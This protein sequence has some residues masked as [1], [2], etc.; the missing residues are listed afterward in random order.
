MKLSQKG[1]KAMLTSNLPLFK[2]DFFTGVDQMIVAMADTYAAKVEERLKSGYKSGTFVTGKVAGSVK[3]GNPTTV[4]GTRMVMVYT[5]DFKARL[6]EF[7]HRNR[8][9]RQ[10]ERVPVWRPIAVSEN[11]TIAAAGLNSFTEMKRVWDADYKPGV[12]KRGR[13]RSSR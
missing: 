2:R 11:Q 1:A 8:Y 4:R 9:T 7:G 13:R 10:F 5:T 6:W 12:K 3:V